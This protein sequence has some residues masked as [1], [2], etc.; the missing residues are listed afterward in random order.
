MEKI[1]ER[2]ARKSNLGIKN[3]AL[4]ATLCDLLS[5]WRLGVEKFGY[6]S[7]ARG[8]GIALAM[9]SEMFFSAKSRSRSVPARAFPI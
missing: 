2:V 8:W 6:T 9:I 5:A 7:S 3:P 1:E 4:R